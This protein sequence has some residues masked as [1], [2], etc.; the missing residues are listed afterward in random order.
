MSSVCVPHKGLQQNL[1]DT[2][3]YD[4]NLTLNFPSLYFGGWDSFK[5]N[6]NKKVAK[7]AH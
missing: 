3:K 5:I 7:M 2:L 6:V 4:K 1:K